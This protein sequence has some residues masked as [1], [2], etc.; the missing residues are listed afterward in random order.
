MN[1]K[2]LKLK[3]KQ[4]NKFDNVVITDYILTKIEIINYS[5]KKMLRILHNHTYR[6]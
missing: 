2:L 1:W 4:L 6:I 3:N 5:K